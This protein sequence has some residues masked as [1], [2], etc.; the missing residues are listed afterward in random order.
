MSR[1][2]RLLGGFVLP[3]G[4]FVPSIIRSIQRGTITLADTVASNTATITAVNM[5]NSRLVCLGNTSENTGGGGS[6]GGPT[7][8]RL[9]FTNSTTITATRT[10]TSGALVIGFEV[11]QYWPGVVRQVQRGTIAV[12]GTSNTATLSPALS[13]TSKAILDMLGLDGNV[14]HQA[15]IFRARMEIT[16]T[17]TVTMSRFTSNNT[18]TGG[19]QVTEFR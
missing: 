15:D 7:Y 12:S 1:R 5:A 13:S 4:M 16:N 18:L 6:G 8:A 9:E 3:N 2:S 11:I 17:T 19:F 10:D 14:A